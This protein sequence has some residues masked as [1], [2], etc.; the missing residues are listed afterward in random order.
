MWAVMSASSRQDLNRSS[1]TI[2]L[3]KH[4]DP[5]SFFLMENP[6]AKVKGKTIVVGDRGGNSLQLG[7]DWLHS[8]HLHLGQIT[9]YG[10]PTTVCMTNDRDRANLQPTQPHTFTC[11]RKKKCPFFCNHYLWH[12]LKSS[13]YITCG[14]FW[15]Q[16][17]IFRFS[18]A[19]LP[20]F[21]FKWCHCKI[22][23]ATFKQHSEEIITKI[24][25]KC[26]KSQ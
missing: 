18:V 1:Q 8:L 23:E 24:T 6:W 14:Q 9:Q 3:T 21:I 17:S 2:P 11:N 4:R 20:S 25:H 13:Y 26:I 7:S 16:T 15:N 19:P 10:L 12:I 5:H 22:K